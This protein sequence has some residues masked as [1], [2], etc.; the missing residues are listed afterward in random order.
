MDEKLDE[1]AGRLEFQAIAYELEAT[2]ER[3]QALLGRVKRTK[4]FRRSRRT[5]GLDLEAPM[6]MQFVWAGCLEAALESVTEA[7]EEV[8]KGA[9]GRRR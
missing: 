6:S 3:L 2:R 8:R 1:R 7:I 4:G 5:F 9:G